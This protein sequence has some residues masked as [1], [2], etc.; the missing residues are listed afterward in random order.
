MSVFL[1]AGHNFLVSAGGRLYRD[2][3]QHMPQEWSD[4][5]DAW[6]AGQKC[7]P[8]L[9]PPAIDLLTPEPDV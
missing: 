1:Q 9:Y 8:T 3:R 6:A 2:Q 7:T 4:L 5:V